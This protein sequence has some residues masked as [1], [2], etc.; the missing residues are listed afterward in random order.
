[1]SNPVFSYTARDYESS[2]KEG[3]ARLPALSNGTWTDLNASDPGIVLIDYMHALVDMCNYYLDHQAMETFI[4][5]A[6]ERANLFRLAKQFSYNV[7]SAKGAKVD[8]IF[9]LEDTH[10]STVI[11]PKHTRVH[12]GT[13]IYFLTM[14]AAY[15]PAGEFEVSVPCTQ[16][17]ITTAEYTGTGIS[18]YSVD[19][20]NPQNQSFTL[21][22]RGIDMSSIEITDNA[23]IVWKS[24]D[25]L[26][27]TESNERAYQKNLNVD[28]SIEILFGDGDRGAIPQP[29]DVLTIRYIT[30]IGDQG[31]VSAMAITTLD[32]DIKDIHGETVTVN[33]INPNP[34]SGGSYEETE[35]EIRAKAPG[36]IKAQDRAV[37]LQDYINL[38]KTIDG[39]YDAKAFDVNNAPDLCLYHEVKV[40]IT[41]DGGDTENTALVN[42]VYDYLYQRMIPPTN[43]QVLAPNYIPVDI[44]VHVSRN[45]VVYKYADDG[46]EDGVMIAI[47][48][49]FQGRRGLIGEDFNPN[50]LIT[51]ITNLPEV[52]SVT[53][54]T[55]SIP[56]E[57]PGISMIIC[58]NVNII[59]E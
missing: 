52:K 22:D 23:G 24:V 39:V 41:P 46:V 2:R 1:M 18:R 37:T 20:E 50:D 45:P 12:T 26:I 44:T 25:H 16:G 29:S 27:F 32:E 31:R 58:G 17:V 3:I 42:E 6:K 10:H 4:P 36:V 43:L 54:I 34:S 59:V 28:N 7:R 48:E 13:G 56:I 40:V 19:V 14:E 47:Q 51:A 38:A 55:P 9:F 11:I 30:T 57:A 5:T 33:V 53:S 35:E 21:I 15:I 8:V 49:Y